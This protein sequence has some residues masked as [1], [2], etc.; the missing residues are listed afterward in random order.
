M[1]FLL[2][3]TFFLFRSSSFFV[4]T[5]DDVSDGKQAI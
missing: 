1:D 2:L 3:G 5:V 4:T